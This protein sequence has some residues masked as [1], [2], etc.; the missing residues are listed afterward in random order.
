MPTKNSKGAVLM[1]GI[2][3]CGY[4]GSELHLLEMATEFA[5]RGYE[6]VLAVFDF[7]YPLLPKAKDEGITVINAHTDPLPYKHFDIFFAQHYAVSD[8]IIIHNE[9]T[10]DRL[11]VSSLAFL[12][13]LESPPIY[14]GEADVILFVSEETRKRH[15]PYL[16][17]VNIENIQV[18][19][20]YAP[21]EYFEAYRPKDQYDVHNIAVISNHI[22]EEVRDFWYI[23]RANGLC[24]DSFGI[25][26]GAACITP[27]LLSGYDVV[28]TI[29]RSAQYCMAQGIPL[30][31]YDYFG[32]PG[33]ITKENFKKNKETNFSGRSVCAKKTGKQI[34]DE[35]TQENAIK[36]EN[37]KYLAQAAH[38][39]FDFTLLFDDFMKKLL[40]RPSRTRNLKSYL[41]GRSIRYADAIANELRRPRYSKVQTR[42]FFDYGDGFV[43]DGTQS[44]SV[45][46][47]TQI[48][49]KITIPKKAQAVRF[50]PDSFWCKCKV[51]S[52]TEEDGREACSLSIKPVTMHETH[53]GW[54]YMLEAEPKY[55]ITYD[56][57]PESITI[58]F[59]L[60]SNF[61]YEFEQL[62][63]KKV[64]ALKQH[65][66]R[67]HKINSEQQKIMSE[68][69]EIL[70]E[71]QRGI[72]EQQK[73]IEAQRKIISEQQEILGERQRGIEEQQKVIEGQQK[74]IGEQAKSI[75]WLRL[76]IYKKTL[77]K[78]RGDLR[79]FLGRNE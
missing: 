50:E 22:C 62:M 54:E 77:R 26:T 72:E 68:Q 70:G 67:L 12:E 55:L 28:I 69:Q 20:N 16:D 25:E 65:G 57:R 23:A 14:A 5:R 37:I 71:R 9:F 40:T 29:G 66:E 78:L 48:V 47:D 19:P 6:I 4:S 39:F 35:I 31:C 56:I 11:A 8:Y 13:P 38:K 73:V 44:F 79:D 46:Y 58:V 17:D 53:N 2:N 63:E 52:L 76:P 41:Q 30:Y 51:I 27:E 43:Q 75:E 15:M 1:T 64:L 45:V 74:V 42:V 33:F 18:F 49:L 34:F 7:A 61:I 24:V 10:F 3:L 59:I 32:G 60:K 36:T 21:R